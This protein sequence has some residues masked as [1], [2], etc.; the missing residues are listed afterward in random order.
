MQ[1]PGEEVPQQGRITHGELGPA[2][3]LQPGSNTHHFCSQLIGQN[4]SHGP[5]YMRG[6]WEIQA[7]TG[8]FREQP[9]FLQKSTL[10]VTKN[11]FTPSLTHTE[12]T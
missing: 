5:A 10:V 2:F 6:G 9:M 12:H 4:K 11:I 1:G 8:I 7:S 3:M